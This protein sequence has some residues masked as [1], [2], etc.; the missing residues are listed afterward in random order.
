MR[1][2]LVIGILLTGC[3]GEPNPC[4]EGFIRNVD[5][6]CILDESDTDTAKDTDSSIDTGDWTPGPCEVP[7]T[8]GTN[9]IEAIGAHDNLEEESS[10]NEPPP[11]LELLEIDVDSDRQLVWGVGQGGLIAY[12]IKNPTQPE[13]LSFTPSGGFQRY[14]H[15]FAL[16]KT[17][18]GKQLLYVSHRSHGLEIFDTDDPSSPTLVY[19][20]KEGMLE[21]MLG[22]GDYLYVASRTGNLLTFDIQDP[23]QPK[24]RATTSGLGLPWT[25][26]GDENALYVAD[27]QKGVVVLDRSS[28]TQPQIT[29]DDLVDGGVQSVA[30]SDTLLVAAAGTKGL[31]LFDRTTPT[32][33]VL[34]SEYDVGTFVQ[35]VRIDGDVIWAVTQESVIAIDASIPQ[36]PQPIGAIQTPY[37]AMTLDTGEDQI[38]VGDWAALRG[39]QLIPDE[40]APHLD[41]AT[42]HVLLDP[43]G[44]ELTVTL[45]NAGNAPL[46]FHGLST[47]DPTLSAKLIGPVQ[48]QSDESTSL[49]I[50]WPGGELKGEICLAS[51]DPDTP[52]W[53]LSVHTGGVQNPA[54][55]SPAPDFTLPDL[56]G[57]MHTLSEQEGHPVVLIY[58]ATW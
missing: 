20:I 7:D 47:D 1:C 16:P 22:I 30:I 2:L 55:G 25:L 39:Y 52:V 37:W 50:E 42:S 48:L 32:E 35:D 44:D 9:P 27:H 54:I 45:R 36:A 58:F 21:D 28:P 29:Q 33:V 38:W 40:K 57:T 10:G 26:T 23:T 19:E 56:D 34:L 17:S 41:P 4:K 3:S 14:H 12:D 18:D 46:R 49:S 51:N 15:V 24:L 31:I 11:M 43:A 6:D 53:S 8:L 5:G 13:L